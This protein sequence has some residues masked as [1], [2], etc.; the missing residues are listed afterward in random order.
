M[1]KR[2]GAFI[3]TVMIMACVFLTTTFAYD[4]EEHDAY[5]EQVL[6]GEKNYKNSKSEKVQN[7]VLMLE[8][9][10]YL[11]IDQDR[12]EGADKL[13]FLKKMKVRGLPKL[14]EFDLTGVFYG[15]HRNY[16]HRGW[17]YTYRIPEGEKHDKANWPVRKKLL[18]STVNKVFD[19]GFKNELFGN[20]CKQC[21][22]FSALVYYVH[23]LWD[24]IEKKKYTSSDLTIPLARDHASEEN[25]DVF[26][27]IKKYSETLFVSQKKNI[28][29]FSFMQELDNLAEKARSLAGTKGGMNDTNFYQYHQYADDLMNLLISYIPLLLENEEFFKTEFY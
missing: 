19:F 18:C 1:I 12:S 5:L 28:T 3:L 21:D 9:A 13:D 24:H 26:W 22:S 14:N 11:A 25:Q 15:N 8:Y 7:K 29:Y 2:T 20:V 17:D 10:S 23:V 27:E 16:T 4:V 6:F